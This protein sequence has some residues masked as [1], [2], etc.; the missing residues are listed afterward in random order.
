MAIYLAVPFLFFLFFLFS[1][2]VPFLNF[3]QQG[4]PLLAGKVKGESIIKKLVRLS[5]RYGTKI[6][7]RDGVGVI[8]L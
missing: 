2:L 3:Y 8:E 7:S 4:T 6:V 5:Q 1:L